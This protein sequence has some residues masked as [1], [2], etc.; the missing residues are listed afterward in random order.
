MASSLEQFNVRVPPDLKKSFEETLLKGVSSQ[1][2]TTA[3]VRL[4]VSLPENIRVELVIAESTGKGDALKD[5]FSEVVKKI[6]QKEIEIY[7]D[8]NGK[9]GR[10][11]G[12]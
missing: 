9:Q 11:G 8:K 10:R 3:M 4:W 2:V 1:H 12:K 7:F 6:C 5:T